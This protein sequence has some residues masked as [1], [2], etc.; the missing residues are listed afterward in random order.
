MNAQEQR[1]IERVR[2]LLRLGGKTNHRAEAEAAVAKAHEIAAG[3]GIAIDGI[4][5]DREAVRITHEEGGARSRSHARKLCH[6][7]LKNH[8]GVCV[9]GSSTHGAAY[10]GPAVN[11][12]VARHVEVFL[13]RQC[14]AL[15][16]AYATKAHGVRVPRKMTQRR[17]AW[18]LGFFAGIDHVLR[19]RP[20]R[21]DSEDI[22]RAIRQYV[23]DRFK[24]KAMKMNLKTQKRH[25]NDL[26]SGFQDGKSTRLDRP[27]EA[28]AETR[29]LNS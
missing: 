24:V 13:L 16:S 9:L 26:E 20:I 27:V 19:Q 10:V 21:N 23:S 4:D 22:N 7:I 2:K 15:W 29:Q 1:I 8:F 14:G 12:A 6:G 18:E 3:A 28:A 17:R 5:A 11:I 25:T